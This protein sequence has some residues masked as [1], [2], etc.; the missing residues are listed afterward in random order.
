MSDHELFEIISMLT[1]RSLKQ[2]SYDLANVGHFG[3]ALRAYVHFTSP[4]RRYPDLLV[5]REV[6][7]ALRGQLEQ[8]AQ[9][10][11]RREQALEEAVMQSKQRERAVMEVER[12]VADV[13]RAWFMRDRVGLE[14][15][16]T[17]VEMLGSSLVVAL[18]DPFVEVRVPLD[19]LGRDSYEI[20]EDGLRVVGMRSGEEVRLGDRML[21]RVIDS[22]VGRRTTQASRIAS[23]ESAPTRKRHKKRNQPEI[24]GKSR[25]HLKKRTKY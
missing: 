17:V 14:V 3:L 2:A 11:E 4:I 15:M 21:V 5:H 9:E 19:Q 16:G 7:R 1:L 23:S 18:D 6:K 25:K 8:S 10:K 13:Y 22:N 24:V 20:A 12:E